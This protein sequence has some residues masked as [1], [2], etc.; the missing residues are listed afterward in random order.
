MYKVKVMGGMISWSLSEKKEKV[1]ACMS[2]D[3]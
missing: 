3:I 1:N 2:V